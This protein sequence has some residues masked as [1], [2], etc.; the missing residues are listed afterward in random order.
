MMTY[1]NLTLD[2]ERALYSETDIVVTNCTFQGE[3]DGESALKECKN[4]SVRDCKFHLRYPFW[5]NTNTEISNCYMAD[6]CRAALWYDTNLKITNSELNGI[7]ALR[8]CSDVFIKDCNITSAEFAWRCKR[9]AIERTT[10][11]KTEYPFF[12]CEGVKI[13]NMKMTGKY[14]FQY[15]TDATIEESE[16]NTKDAFWHSKD[17]TIKDSTLVGEYIGWYS[18]NLKLINCTIEGTQPFCYCKNLILENCTMH[19]CDLA[20]ERSY[21]TATLTAPVDSI[22]EPV[23]G[24]IKII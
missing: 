5:H 8:E 12:M 18:E 24:E 17:V 16:F 3:A 21:V 7:K 20:F 1:S 11:H 22:Q 13:R 14:S 4:V 6:T 9:L 19:N 15:V 2:K 10:I 23:F